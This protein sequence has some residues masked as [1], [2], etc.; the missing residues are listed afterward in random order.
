MFKT[1]IEK[2]DKYVEKMDTNKIPN[3]DMDLA[4]EVR[5]RIN[6][7]D[8]LYK[9]VIEKHSRYMHLGWKEQREFELLR[10]GRGSFSITLPAS[11]DRLEMDKLI[12][13]MEMYMES[14]YYLAG[15][16]RTA[17]TKSK[18]LPGL[19]SF[20]CEGAR[21]VRNKLLEH[22]EG[23]DSKVY[24]QSV[25]FGGEEGPRLKAHRP[26]DQ[27]SIFPDKGIEANALEIKNNLEKLLDITLL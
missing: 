9:I 13:E 8:Y 14:F 22:V 15:R 24:I 19:E 23:K 6:Q 11:K 21:N 27:E 7:L 25:G 18:P 10:A 26:E 4:L 20:E 16:M 17:I 2:F 5:K 3:F 12:F 1:V